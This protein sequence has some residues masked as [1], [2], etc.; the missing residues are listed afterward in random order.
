MLLIFLGLMRHRKAAAVAGEMGLTNSSISHALRRLREVFGD[1]LFLRQPHGLEPTAF[2]IGIEDRVRAAVASLDDAL[3]GEQEFDPATARAHLRISAPDHALDTLVA[4]LIARAAGS[5]P[6]LTWAIRSMGREAAVSGLA[7][8]EIDIALGFFW[9]LPEALEARPLLTE[10]YLVAARAEHPLMA[11]ELDLDSYAA[12]DHLLVSGDGSMRGIVDRRLEALG[13]SR[14]VCLSLPLFLPALTLLGRSDLVATLPERM[15][16]RH[17]E[18]FGLAFR[19]PPLEIRS[20]DVRAVW[21]R[22]N[23][24]N[25]LVQWVVDLLGECAQAA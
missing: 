18:R 10:G 22:R 17:G 20:F 19:P 5:A 21:H 2:A 6:G 3:A 23:A 9:D 1:P 8:N 4:D 16:R 24:R 11:R 13:R 15:V 25:G 12:A 14:R 7:G